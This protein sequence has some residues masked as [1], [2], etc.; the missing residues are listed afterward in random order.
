MS[1]A[2]RP[3]GPVEVPPAVLAVA[4]GAEPVPVWRNELGGLTF[5]LGEGG[6]RRFV[7]WSPRGSGPSLAVEASRLAWAGRHIVVP[8][9]L[10]A[11]GDDTGEW[12]LTAGLPGVS[13]VD[14]S[15]LDSPE[16][17]LLAV[18]AIGA[19]LRVLHDA[20]PVEGCPFSWSVEERTRVA[21]RRGRRVAEAL[22]HPPAA[23]RLVVCHGDA[24]APNTLLLGD[25]SFSGH[26]DLG[27]LG[28]ADRWADLAVA[29]WSTQWN[30]GD[31]YEGALLEAYGIE[32]DEE[33]ITYYRA[34]WD[35]T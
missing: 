22:R 11:G 8:R 13:A 2:S 25:G 33:R 17:S 5:E 18:R 16:R 7:K 35:A 32:R 15:F 4:D 34:L 27:S 19:G 21:E 6:G 31:G 23:D 28:V 1:L 24:C 9:V 14:E 3:S 10:D 30:Y 26:V 29:S 20:L 12:M